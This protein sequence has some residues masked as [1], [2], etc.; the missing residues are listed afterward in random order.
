MNA[1]TEK[2]SAGF[3]QLA[4]PKIWIASAIP[5]AVAFVFSYRQARPGSL[6][7]FILA[8]ISIFLIE[9]GKNAVNEVVDY[10]SG[11]D[12]DIDEDKKTHF[13]GGK[14]TIVQGKLTVSQ[15]K[16][17]AVYTYIPAVVI[18]LIIVVFREFNV[19][20]I[21]I[22]GVGASLLYSIP[23]FKFAYR[24]LGEAAVGFTFGPLLVSGMNLML[25]GALDLKVLAVS[26]PIGLLIANVLWINQFPDYETDKKGDKRNWVVRLGR[27][28]SA[29]I[30]GLLFLSAYL[31]FIALSIIYKSYIMLLPGVSVPFAVKSFKNAMK[32]YDDIQKLTFSNLSTIRIYAIT[33]ATLI[34]SYILHEALR[35]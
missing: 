8:V 16:K 28:S 5:M 9:I 1:S 7:W 17:A 3:W 14:K 4:D 22:A 33:G 34:I 30:H 35:I 15:V 11:V 18:G 20:W 13:S 12:R 10:H 21:G 2:R 6:P 32:N 31:C 29:Y 24:G 23:P 26:V 25:T 19:I 27:K